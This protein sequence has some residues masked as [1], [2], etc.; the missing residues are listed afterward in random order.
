[1]SSGKLKTPLPPNCSNKS[2]TSF[3]SRM[4]IST[5]LTLLGWS[6]FGIRCAVPCSKNGRC[7]KN[8]NRRSKR[9][10]NSNWH[11]SRQC[12]GICRNY[13]ILAFW[14]SLK[15]LA[16]LDTSLPKNRV[17]RHSSTTSTLQIWMQRNSVNSS[18][19]ARHILWR[20]M[21]LKS[22]ITPSLCTRLSMCPNSLRNWL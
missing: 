17:Q 20:A 11:L 12:R 10:I 1:M 15:N 3:Q 5:R 16:V 18:T 19:W 7:H 22:L 14:K 6:T 21:C 13:Q 2:L 4:K 8:C 9:N